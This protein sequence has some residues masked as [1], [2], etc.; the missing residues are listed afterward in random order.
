MFDEDQG[1]TPTAEVVVGAALSALSLEDLQERVS[2]LRAEIT[3]VEAE[4]E[5][6]TAG[7]AAAEAFFN[8]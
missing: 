1:K 8:S 3:R 5:A 7:K 6:K 2:A 4:I